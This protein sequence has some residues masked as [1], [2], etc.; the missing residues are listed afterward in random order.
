MENSTYP[1]VPISN[2]LIFENRNK[3]FGAYHLWEE[4]HRNVE[5][6]LMVCAAFL[7]FVFMIP[8]LLSSIV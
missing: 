6:A 2:D 3:T 5:I 8:V 7:A 4:Y 1:Q